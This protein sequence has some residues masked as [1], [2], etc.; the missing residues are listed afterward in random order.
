MEN[1]PDNVEVLFINAVYPEHNTLAAYGWIRKGS[2]A[3]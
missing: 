2:N 3:A 1:K